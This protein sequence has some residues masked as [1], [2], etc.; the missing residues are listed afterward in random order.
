MPPESRRLPAPE[1]PSSQYLL[2]Y[3]LSLPY[4]L[5]LNDRINVD[6]SAS[7]VSLAFE[8]VTTQ[9]TKQILGQ[10]SGWF[11]Q[12][13][14]EF[15]AVA[16]SAQVMFTFIADRNIESMVRGTVIA[17]FAISAILI[18]AL[19]HLGL[20][21]LSLVPN[22]LPILAAFGVW[23]G[24]NGEIGFSVAMI[25]SLSLGIVVD[26]TVHFLMK[27]NRARSEQG[28]SADAAI[29]YA[30]ESVGAAIVINTV[31]LVVGF[32]VLTQST[33]KPIVDI[34]LLTAISIVL[35]LVL[36]FLLLPPLLLWLFRKQPER[37]SA[38][39]VSYAN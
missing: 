29:R 16:A 19:R 20:G 4:G 17:I 12:N 33:F 15:N 24:I 25:G 36:D 30:F 23:G 10:I 14:P 27:F 26:D 7:R 38:E 8:P 3:E 11:E 1:R 39:G 35:A 31:I 32:L 9:E 21:L 6:K 13:A 2:L 22:G 5:D 37:Q 18:M 34:G 28:M